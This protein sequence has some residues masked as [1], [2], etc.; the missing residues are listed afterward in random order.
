V[1]RARWPYPRVLAHRGAGTLAPE[2]TVAA[3]R[4]GWERGF[5]AVEFDVMLS[6]DE[7][8]VLMHDPQFGRT[9]KGVGTVAG[10]PAK[11]L[12]ECD[13][14]S[15][16]DA[17]FAGERVP[18]FATALAFCRSH[19]I[20][21]NI[22]I[23]ATPGTERRTG[24]VVAAELVD[25]GTPFASDAVPPL[26]SSFSSAALEGAYAVAPEVARA[27]LFGRIPVDWHARLR[28]LDCSALHCDQSLL[29]R[30][31]VDA[32]AGA[33]FGVFCYTVNEPPRARELLGWGVDAFCTDR[34][35]LIGADFA[36]LQH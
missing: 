25:G 35:D 13:A 4:L 34:I 9:V 28:A 14:G 16:F 33:G 20:F 5:R 15:W 12:V 10:T 8:P 22:E 3:L 31:D 11:E 29:A 30:A 26:I 7:I 17:R 6:A 24:E 27:H 36:E 32:I 23:K 21:M 19:G 18:L 2:N 1:T